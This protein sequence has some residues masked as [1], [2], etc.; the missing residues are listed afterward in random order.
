MEEAG[1]DTGRPVRRSLQIQARGREGSRE[2]KK[3]ANWINTLE[4]EG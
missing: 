4:V 3:E 2:E 1:E